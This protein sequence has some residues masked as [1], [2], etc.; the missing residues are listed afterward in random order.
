[1]AGTGKIAN[2]KK[3]GYNGMVVCNDLECEWIRDEKH[4]WDIYLFE[5][6]SNLKYEDE[7]VECVCTSPTYGNRLADSY[8]R[9]DK[10]KRFSYRFNL[11]KKLHEE[12]TGAMHWGEKYK[13]KHK[14][15]WNEMKRV[16]VP[17]GI[18]ILNISNHIR[19]GE[20]MMVSEWHKEYIESIGFKLIE[21]HKIETPRLRYGANSKARVGFENLFVFIKK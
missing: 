21:S 6:A 9:K 7:V 2:V 8:N 13:N 18:F 17:N 5:D 19:K 14:E 12:N 15:I 10:S 1:M 11:G 16:L 3:H 20:E 4:Q